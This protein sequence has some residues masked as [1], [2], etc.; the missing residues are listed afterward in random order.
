MSPVFKQRVLSA[1]IL[2]P[3]F[4]AA[5]YWGGIPFYAVCGLAL[6][7]SFN[8]WLHLS[9]L[10]PTARR[11]LIV[12]GGYLALC[13]IAFIFLRIGMPHG[14]WVLFSLLF[15]IWACDIS[16]YF[17]GKKIGGPK[18]APR[19]SPN[20]TWSGMGGGALASGIS[21]CLSDVAFNIIGFPFLAFII[22]VF[23]AFVGQAGD[24]LISWQ[25]RRVGV[26]DT[27]SIIPGHGGILDRIDS[28]LLASPVF[29]V[30]LWVWQGW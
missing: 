2:G 5:V 16:A 20:K 25:K 19:I 7:I 3:M 24:L 14:A 6:T 23:L 17:T 11:D 29:L 1:A 8:E 10:S 27:G 21:L 9:A 18:M 26:K 13:F 12:G 15:T 30:F 28:L 4:L 22:G